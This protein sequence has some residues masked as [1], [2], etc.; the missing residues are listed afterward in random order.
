M[1]DIG[2]L[3]SLANAA[4]MGYGLY[5]SPV[6][7]TGTQE[8]GYRLTSTILIIIGVVALMAVFYLY[9]NGA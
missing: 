9:M 2:I 6:Y 8:T 1:F 5:N 7:D 3:Y 4:K